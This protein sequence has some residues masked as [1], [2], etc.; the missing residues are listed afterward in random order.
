M[1]GLAVA[2]G[3]AARESSSSTTTLL[4]ERHGQ[5]GTETSSRNSEVVHAGL[6]Y[7]PRTLKTRLCLPGRVS[8]YAFCAR[9]SVP[10]A[11]VGKWVVAQDGAQREA[12]EDL[13]AHCEALAADPEFGAAAP[14][15]RFLSDAEARA[16]E[17]AV[18]ADAG[19]L[20]SPETGIVDSHALML[21]LHGLFEDAGGVTAL[22]SAVVGIEPLLSSP[23]APPG[24]GGWRLT[25]RDAATGAESTIEAET[26]INSAGLGAVGIHNMIVAG[27]HPERTVRAHYAKGSYFSYGASAPRVRRLVYPAPSA[28]HAG[29][30]THLTLDLAGRMRF[31]PD[32][33]WVEDPSDLAVSAARLPA[34]LAEIRRYL[35]DVDAEALAP[36]YAGVRPKL[37]RLS[38]VGAGPGF[39]DF[40]VAREQGYEGWVDLLGME[41]PGL[42]SCLAVA[43]YVRDLLY[44]SQ[45]R[46]LGPA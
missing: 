23:S 34:A 42:T 45:S 41:S 1:I 9:H 5:V 7:G 37:G 24:S 21:A 8:L 12:L 10:H 20:E 28:G 39:Q 15:V 38:G 14:P 18:R 16:L 46:D 17:P 4:L 36:D 33:E 32:A 35:P 22:N 27:R 11:R 31:G 44:G 13:R 19:V 30:G 3:L 26:I 25:V 29:L 43:E 6:Y 40:R 2:R